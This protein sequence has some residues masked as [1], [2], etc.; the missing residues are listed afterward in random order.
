VHRE[1]PSRIIADRVEVTSR[2]PVSEVARPAAQEGI[3]LLHGVIDRAQQPA[4]I[5]D[6]A[7]SVASA[8]H[9]LT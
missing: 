7:D 1:T 8:L 6:L 4:A 5:R 3:D 9:P 2:V